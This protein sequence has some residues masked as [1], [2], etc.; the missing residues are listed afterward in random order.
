MNLNR[1]HVRDDQ[2]HRV[3]Q[4]QGVLLQLPKRRRQILCVC[5]LYSQAKAMPAPDIGPPS[6]PPVFFAPFSKVNHS[7][8]GSSSSGG[9]RA[10]QATQGDEMTLGAAALGE[11]TLAANPDEFSDF[12][13]VVTDTTYDGFSD[14]LESARGMQPVQTRLSL[15]GPYR[16]TSGFCNRWSCSSAKRAAS[17]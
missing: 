11:R 8:R 2:Q 14:S 13:G 15:S 5:P 12:S 4:R 10:Q 9:L 1:L 7:P 16:R 17:R 6:P 3:F